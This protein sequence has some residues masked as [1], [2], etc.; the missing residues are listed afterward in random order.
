[1]KHLL[2]FLAPRPHT[3]HLLAGLLFVFA[4]ACTPLISLYDAD[5]FTQT[6]E[7]KARALV[8]MDH[9]VEQYTSYS[10]DADEVLVQ[11]WS[12]YDRQKVRHQ[13]QLSMQQWKLLMDDNVGGTVKS[14]L[15]S[16]FERWKAEGTVG[17]AYIREKKEVVT[18]AFDEILELEGAKIKKGQ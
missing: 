1:M 8:L 9:G 2:T 16:F 14:I 6:S 12:L 4:S 3:R 15:P 10:R 11:A 17:K 5:T 18:K 13:N 7:L